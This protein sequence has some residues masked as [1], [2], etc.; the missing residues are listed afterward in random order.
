MPGTCEPTAQR[1]P[2]LSAGGRCLRAR[3]GL[4]QG[5]GSG[6]GEGEG[7]GSGCTRAPGELRPPPRAPRT[8]G[9]ASPR[10]ARGRWRRAGSRGPA[11]AE[12]RSRR[13]R[14]KAGPPPPPA[15]AA[16]PPSRRPSAP[17][18]ADSG[19]SGAARRAALLPPGLWPPERRQPGP[20]P[21]ARVRPTALLPHFF[22]GGGRG[23]YPAPPHGPPPTA[24]KFH[25]DTNLS[26]GKTKQT[27]E[28][29]GRRARGHL[30]FIP[31]GN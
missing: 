3:A 1:P 28:A 9:S 30:T 2:P 12:H 20:R 10:P 14:R 22:W 8:P 27:S 19:S 31:G 15:P 7:G 16:P 26:R 4:P 5:R 6:A 21:E 23:G 29:L 18:P 13:P 25:T 17:S 24:R 11:R